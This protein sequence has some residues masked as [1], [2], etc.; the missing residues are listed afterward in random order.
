MPQLPALRAHH[1]QL[2][3]LTMQMRADLQMPALMKQLEALRGAALVDRQFFC[4]FIE[5]K[6]L[7]P[8]DD[9]ALEDMVRKGLIKDLGDQPE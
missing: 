6:E 3:K 9:S 7:R 2:A 5:R 4:A 1:E 8:E